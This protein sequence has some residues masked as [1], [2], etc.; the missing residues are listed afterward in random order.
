MFVNVPM[1]G[2]EQTA[3]VGYYF[4]SN[5]VKTETDW[6]MEHNCLNDANCRNNPKATGYECVCREGF[7]GTYC[8]CKTRKYYVI[9]DSS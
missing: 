6:C 3:Q 8:Q 2:L 1:D 5:R 7:V 4:Q 9:S